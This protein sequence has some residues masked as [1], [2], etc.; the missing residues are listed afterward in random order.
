M[1]QNNGLRRHIFE[2]LVS[3]DADGK[4]F[5][6]LAASWRAVDDSTWEFKLRP[7]V[8]FT[9]GADFTARDVI[10][11]VCRIPTVENSPSN[12]TI[13]T[14]GI[15]GMESPDPLTLIIKT[16]GPY[17]L[18][19][20]DLGAFGILSAQV[21]GAAP[22]LA[23]KKG[24]CT[25]LGTPPKS[26]DFNDPAKAVG[27]GPYKLK[28]YSRG[29]QL[30]LERNDS[31]WGDKPHWKTVTFRPI[32]AAGPRVAALLAG[33]VDMIENPPIQ[34]FEQVKKAGLTI[35]QGL[36]NRIIYVHLDQFADPAWKTPGVKGTDGKNPFLDKRVRQ[37]MSKA[38]NRD[39][40]VERIMGGVAIPAGELLPVP[41]FGTSPDRKPEKFDPEGAKKLLAEA[42][43]PNGFELVLGSPNDRYINDEK[44]AQAVAQMLTRIGIKTSVE[45]DDR[46]HLL[47]QAQQVRIL[48]LSG[49]LGRR[50]QRDVELHRGPHRDAGRRAGLRQHEPRPLHQQDRRRPHH[51][52]PRHHRRQAA[53]K[54][55]ATGLQGGHGGLR[56][57]PAPFRGDA[58]GLQADD[59]LHAPRGPVHARLRGEAG[60]VK[61]AGRER[62]AGPECRPS[63]R[64]RNPKCRPAARPRNP[65]CRPAAR[66]RNPKC[67]PAARPGNPGARAEGCPGSSARL[68][69]KRASILS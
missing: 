31:Y 32:T 60:E 19:P 47:H 24:G 69:A 52:G 35:V 68:R 17:P 13:S 28:E 26:V 61:S 1:G 20:L 65:K 10:Y 5:P 11:S 27:T 54:P 30:V 9:N 58:L 40:I 46:L 33:D 15:E 8:K 25:G 18:M 44:V 49:G 55:A 37:A 36:S 22:D 45:F 41:L 53:R 43:Y 50:H 29:T 48:R 2:L 34:D 14:K 23:F 57:H 39:A 3:A 4:P 64:P 66:P 56:H 67:R 59:H 42:G 62:R 6:R 16:K 63:A 51:Q 21:S 38:I 12:F 7:G